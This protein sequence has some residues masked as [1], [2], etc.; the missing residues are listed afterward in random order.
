[1]KVVYITNQFHPFSFGGDAKI[2]MYE[3]VELA[4]Q[5]HD[6]HVIFDSMSYKRKELGCK[7][8]DF[9]A[10]LENLYPQIVF[11]DLKTKNWIIHHSIAWYL[12]RNLYA[13]KYLNKLLQQIK[14]DIVHVHNAS[15]MGTE[16]FR[17]CKKLKIACVYTA[18]D[19][20]LMDSQITVPVIFICD[21]IKR[22]M[23]VKVSSF[24]LPNCIPKCEFAP[25]IRN[26]VST[27]LL[28]VGYMERR[29]N[30]AVAV[31]AADNLGVELNI[32][33]VGD[34]LY[35]QHIRTLCEDKPKIKYLGR[36]S[37]EVL[38][39]LYSTS[40]ILLLPT[41]WDIFPVALLEAMSYG[42]A[43]LAT[44]VGGISEMIPAE[45]ILNDSS[46]E[47][48]CK[49]IK[50]VCAN[51]GYYQQLCLEQSAAFFVESHVKK[52]LEIYEEVRSKCKM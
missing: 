6:V 35:M 22:S 50:E 38:K 8:K 15:S 18:H 32:V 44:S 19:F 41:D 11:H 25:F 31:H 3:A 40:D 26:D 43:V 27:K 28:F 37:E 45:L 30:A 49:K 23:N 17:A 48:L 7:I 51:L 14:P 52:L 24:M 16:P 29:K 42:C 5:G 33:G 4:K 10:E 1:M 36:V 39:T 34:D 13:K 46:T 20:Y 9:E 2:V 12:Q 47:E 21:Y